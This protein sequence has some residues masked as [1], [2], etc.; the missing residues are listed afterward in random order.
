M[1]KIPVGATIAHAYRF[2]FQEYLNVARVAWL[3][4]VL[5]Y[6]GMI[7]VQLQIAALPAAI[8][9]HDFSAIT[10]PVP[11]IVLIYAAS[12]VMSLMLIT[13]VFQYAL[14]QSEAKN[15]WYYFSLAKPMWRVLGAIGLMILALLGLILVLIIATLIVL[16]FFRLGLGAVHISD[17]A[18]KN[19]LGFDTL[20][21]FVVGYCAIIFCILRFGFLICATTIAE[22][23]IGLTRSWTLSHGNFWRI[24][25]ILLAIFLPFMTLEFAVMAAA[26]LFP[27]LPPPGATVAQLQAFQAERM[28]RTTAAMG[29]MQHY[30][31]VAYPVLAVFVVFLYGAIAGAQSFAYRV[32]TGTETTTSL[33]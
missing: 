4:L 23:K 25:V 10:M 33:P 3:P 19:I 8:A 2:A 5:T 9:A 18:I 11:L 6:A 27:H 22:G 16:F 14:G 12:M 29:L 15:R 20:L 28:A 32:L 13:G 30:W 17:T 7:P 31:Y 21:A 26:G 1:K 24:L